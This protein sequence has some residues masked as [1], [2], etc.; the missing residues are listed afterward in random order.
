MSTE[1]DFAGLI[2]GPPKS[3]KTTVMRRWVF[4]FLKEHPTGIAIVHDTQMQF[5]D[6]CE[7]Y[8]TADDYRAKA[9]AAAKSNTPLAR[10]IAITTHE[11]Q[12][13][14]ELALGMGEHH[15]VGRDHKRMPIF[16]ALDE[17]S[18]LESTG[19]TYIAKLDW[20][21]ATTRRHLGIATA[22]NL[23]RSSS[24]PRGYYEVVTDVIIFR[25]TSDDGARDLEVKLGLPKMQLQ[26]L[27]GAPPFRSAHWKQGEG[28]V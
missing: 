21:I 28:L 12:T 9:R 23:Q 10:G 2:V 16:L 5:K 4:E 18:V 14:L 3:G 6:L 27:V 20:R 17:T 25:Q 26:S 19:S 24:L 1:V 11:S 7:S 13:V 8:A 15:N 22:H